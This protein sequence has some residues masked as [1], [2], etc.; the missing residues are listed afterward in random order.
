LELHP[1]HMYQ[2]RVPL[3]IIVGPEWAVHCLGVVSKVTAGAG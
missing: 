1:S 2:F 3:L